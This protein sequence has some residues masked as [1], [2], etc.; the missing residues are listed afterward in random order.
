MNHLREEGGE[1]NEKNRENP[2]DD[3]LA[4]RAICCCHAFVL[5]SKLLHNP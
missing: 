2:S 4:L 5:K 3:V 1:R